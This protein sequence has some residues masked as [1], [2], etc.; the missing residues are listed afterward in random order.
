MTQFASRTVS[1]VH[2]DDE[3]R[4]L[5]NPAARARRRKMLRL[6]HVALLTK[7][8]ARLR[9]RHRGEVP[10]FDPLDGG[11]NASMLFLFEKP[12]PMTRRGAGSGFISR[13]NDDPSAEATFRF[14]QQAGIPRKE[15]LTWNVIPWWNGTRKI[16]GQ[17]IR[18][19]IF[20]LRELIEL[21]PRLQ[22]I[23]LVGNTASKARPYL[24]DHGIAVF[25]SPHPSPLV[26][27]SHPEA[28]HS[29]PKLWGRA[30]RRTSPG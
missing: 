21:L 4:T 27:A 16:T 5:R 3:A 24:E 13:N 12:G 25:S 2:G 14:M 23:V 1:N 30:F 29:I 15:T 26:R 28:W 7:F 20:S 8:A 11:V 17:E 22:A 19:G 18:D 10:E 9:S 6:R